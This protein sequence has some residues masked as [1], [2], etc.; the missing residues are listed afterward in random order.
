MNKACLSSMVIC[1]QRHPGEKKP[2]KECFSGFLKMPRFVKLYQVPL[3]GASLA[4]GTKFIPIRMRVLVPGNL[5]FNTPTP[6]KRFPQL[7]RS[8][9][10]TVTCC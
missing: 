8:S 6:T 1:T 9:H 5:P 2:L 10:L 7:A 3:S 4:A